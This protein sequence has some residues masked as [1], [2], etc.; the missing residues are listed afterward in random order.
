MI[1]KHTFKKLQS[2]EEDSILRIKD[3]VYSNQVLSFFGS[4]I[5]LNVKDK[6]HLLESNL[7]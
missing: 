4:Y 3:P 6:S 7:I 2:I 5:N 1:A